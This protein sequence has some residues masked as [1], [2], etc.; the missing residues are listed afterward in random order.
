[1]LGN[2][3]LRAVCVACTCL[4]FGAAAVEAPAASAT[5]ASFVA[6][7]L[8][9]GAGEAVMGKLMAKAGLDPTANALSEISA[10]LTQL[11]N[12]IKALQGTSDR[13]LKEVLDAS[14]LARYDQL[15]ISTITRFQEDLV[16]YVDPHRTLAVRETCRTRF[17]LQ[18]P[19]AQLWR[20]ADKIHDLLVHPQ[21]TI[22]ESYAKSLVGTRPFY[23]V[24][25][26]RKVTEF[27]TYLDDLLVTATTLSVEAHNVVGAEGGPKAVE[28]AWKASKREAES[29]SRRRAEQLVRNPVAPIPGPLD[30]VQKL[31]LNPTERGLHDYWIA[32][33]I[34]GIWRLPTHAELLAMVQH[35]GATT[36]R[37]YLIEQAGMGTALVHVAEFG[38][39]GEL[40]TSTE[41]PSCLTIYG[42]PCHLAIST[43]IAYTRIKLT[44]HGST[45]PKYH[46]IQVAELNPHEKG[47][48]AFLFK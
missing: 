20:A 24:E 37:K 32:A 5:P 25:D 21:T 46:S 14:L 48:Y 43:N 30:T 41:V 33:Q 29:L 18:A 27:F 6:G 45:V 36:V 17:A 12:Q 19:S 16:C 3:S 31:W 47:R 44:P 34:H 15:E 42:A 4:A 22:V 10:Q 26:Q 35:H 9:S 39:T 1:M 2:G 7:K 28:D 38:E 23:T 8:A 11:S 13:T 40:W